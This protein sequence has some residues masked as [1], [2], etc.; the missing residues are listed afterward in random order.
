[1]KIG[2]EYGKVRIRIIIRMALIRWIAIKK[3]GG[4]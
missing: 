3:S 4:I 1:M 2:G